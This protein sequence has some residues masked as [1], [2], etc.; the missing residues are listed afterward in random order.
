MY[1][2]IAVVSPSASGLAMGQV[3]GSLFAVAGILGLACVVRPRSQLLR[4]GSAIAAV[5]GPAVR[6]FALW[7]GPTTLDK[8]TEA[9][10]VMAWML[11]AVL[12]YL[13]WPVILPPHI[14]A[15]RLASRLDP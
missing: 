2:S 9:T 10:A 6:A 3:F 12:A 13:V 8:A 15:A 1:L 5:T 7:V 11:V 4:H 14:D